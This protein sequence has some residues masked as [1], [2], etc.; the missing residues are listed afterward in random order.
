MLAPA[1]RQLPE[2]AAIPLRPCILPGRHVLLVGTP[3][4]STAYALSSLLIAAVS[5][6][7]K[8]VVSLATCMSAVRQAT[9]SQ[10]PPLCASSPRHLRN[11]LLL[12]GTVKPTSALTSV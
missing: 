7:D 9:S 8:M 6:L 5:S 12:G 3:E 10:A 1:Y 4:A 11:L 2:R